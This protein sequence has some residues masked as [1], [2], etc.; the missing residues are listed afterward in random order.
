[1]HVY[2]EHQPIRLAELSNLPLFSKNYLKK[3]SLPILKKVNL[4]RFGNNFELYSGI[5]LSLDTNQEI[6]WQYDLGN[7]RSFDFVKMEDQKPVELIEVKSGNTFN[8][9]LQFKQ[10]LNHNLPI[11]YVLYDKRKTK[12]SR[13]LYYRLKDSHLD[14]YQI[15]DVNDIA[16]SYYFRGTELHKFLTD[17]YE[18]QTLSKQE[19]IEFTQ[20]LESFFNWVNDKKFTVDLEE[21]RFLGDKAPKT[22]SYEFTKILKKYT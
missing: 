2:S 21:L 11:T 15:L 13:E 4:L 16:S 18:Y 14:S 6:V 5:L 7:N 8:S 3:H 9:S 22:R 17:K 20:N 1:M 19:K 10:A 12:I